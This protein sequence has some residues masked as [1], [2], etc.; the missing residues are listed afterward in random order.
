MKPS[1][2]LVALALL[3]PA[4][5]ADT[6]DL[7]TH[8]IFSIT[9]PKGWTFA[10]TKVQ[11]TGYAVTLTPPADVNAK[12]LL[13]LIYSSREKP[14]TK[15]EVQD[16]V[17]NIGD[18]FVGASVEKKKELRDFTMAKGFGVYSVFT[19]ASL[20]GKAPEKDNFKAVAVGMIQ[21]SDDL[22]AAV[23]MLNDDVNGPDLAAMLKAVSGATIT[24]RK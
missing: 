14:P 2:L 11:D 1:L 15:E 16:A 6:L 20:V 21:Y 10:A 19:D 24:S 7:G 3:S 9:P 22:S 5:R 12:C 8:G 13:T 18:Q 17:L 23:S 4:A